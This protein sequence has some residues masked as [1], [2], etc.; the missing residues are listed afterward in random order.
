MG[1]MTKTIIVGNTADSIEAVAGTAA[2]CYMGQVDAAVD[3]ITERARARASVVD[4]ACLV[5]SQ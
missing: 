2:K 5:D 1:A 4:V 3:N